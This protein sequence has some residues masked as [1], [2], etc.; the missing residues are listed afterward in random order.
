M[1][2]P[3]VYEVLQDKVFTGR[4]HAPHQ[5]E[6]VSHLSSLVTAPPTTKKAVSLTFK[7]IRT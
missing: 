6:T 1:N 2:S 5:S 7:I 4:H 3:L